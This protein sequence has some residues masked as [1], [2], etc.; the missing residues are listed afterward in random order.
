MMSWR[1]GIFS[2][3]L[4]VAVV[5]LAQKN[6][7]VWTQPIETFQEEGR[8]KKAEPR[9][10]GAFVP[11][12]QQEATSIASTIAISEKNIFNPDRREFS[13]ATPEPSK[14]MARPQIILYGVT[15]AKDF[16]AASL[17]QPGR[18]LRKGEREMLTLKI[19]EKVGE[20]KLAK[21]LP[22][23]ITLESGEDSFE[24]LLYDANAPKKRAV[25]RT[26]VK[27]AEVKSTAPAPVAAPSP[28][29]PVPVPKAA[30]APKP[31]Q[32]SRERVMEAP[33]PRPVTPPSPSFPGTLRGRTPVR[34]YTPP[35][36]GTK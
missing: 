32:P 35:E 27:P 28:P 16:E 19:G 23:R 11:G 14:P 13:F 22:D 26:E 31:G 4:F 20:Y 5:L 3:L 2:L 1:Y 9:V 10:E 30:E 8:A 17:V 36:S 18:P 12:R 7:H 15:I 24:V 34:P 6:Y 21:V 29:A 33:L 25:V